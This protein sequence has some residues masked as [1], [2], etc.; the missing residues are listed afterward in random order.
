MKKAAYI[1]CFFLIVMKT[2][3]AYNYQYCDSHFHLTNYVQEG[4]SIKKLIPMM[5]KLSIERMAIFGIPLAQK[6]NMYEYTMKLRPNYYLNTEEELYY[7]SAVDSKIAREFLTLPHQMQKRFDPM[8]TGFNPTDGYAVSHIKNM[9]TLYP[10][11]FSGIGEF[12]IY[13]EVVSSK[14]LGDHPTLGNPALENIL[15]FAGKVGM[16]AIMHSDIDSMQSVSSNTLYEPMYLQR[17]KQ[18]FAR[19]PNTI[20]IWAHT[21][22]GRY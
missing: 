7:F 10:G 13:K 3:F 8:I 9:L 19:H 11:V 21:G 15:N 14:V 6:W 2:C 18:L 22:L 17:M 16:V 12:T 20:I 1:T 4:Y 5:D